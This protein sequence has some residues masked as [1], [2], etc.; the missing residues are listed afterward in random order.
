MHT[1][2]A[3]PRLLL[4]SRLCRLPFL[5][6]KFRLSLMSS[7]P[8]VR[9]VSPARLNA[10]QRRAS[11]LRWAGVIAAVVGA[12]FIAAQWFERHHDTFKPVSPE[13]IPVQVA[14]LKPER[15]E[16]QAAG[17]PPAAQS[18]PAAPKRRAQP[19]RNLHRLLRK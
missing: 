8:A 3:L 14:L 12:H 13:H 18:R 2:R 4:R 15:I 19:S 1:A 7:A 17:S 16:T 10:A 6:F 11:R 9:S 5:F